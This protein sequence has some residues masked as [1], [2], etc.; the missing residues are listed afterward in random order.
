M[1]ESVIHVSDSEFDREILKSDKP[2]LVD[3]WAP[4]CGP[5]QKIG[6]VVEEL[7]SEYKDKVKI[8]KINIDDNRQV[9]GTY[10]VMSIPTLILFKGGS[11][12]DKITGLVPKDRL[13]DLLNKAL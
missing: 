13:K 9:A 11:V 1:A 2:A 3:F 12:V 5:C 7:A 10:G 8:A 4:W 6:P